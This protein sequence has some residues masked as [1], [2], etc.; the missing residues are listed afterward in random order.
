MPGLNELKLCYDTAVPNWI[1]LDW[2]RLK[3]VPPPLGTM[4]TI[5]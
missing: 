2:H 3:L 5:R 1:S 4:V